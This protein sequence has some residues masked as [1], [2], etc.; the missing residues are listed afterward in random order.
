METVTH[1]RKRL[2]ETLKRDKSLLGIIERIEV[3]LLR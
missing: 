2:Q 1:E 3:S